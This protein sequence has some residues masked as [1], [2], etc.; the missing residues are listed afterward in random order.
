[1]ATLSPDKKLAW[2]CGTGN[3][4]VARGLVRHFDHIIASDSNVEQLTL[5]CKRTNIHYVLA[6]A[7]HCPVSGRSVDAITVAQALHWFDL[8]GFY[9]EVRRVLKPGG[10]IAVWAYH[11]FQT[12]PE[13]DRILASFYHDILGPYWSPRIRLL[14]ER[15]STL[16]FPFDE[17]LPPPFEMAM[18]WG[19]HDFLGF[20]ASWSP[21][22]AF[23][24]ANGYHPLELI[25]GE[26]HAAWGPADQE[27][28][29]RVPIWL[30]VGRNH[31]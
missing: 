2:D 15:Y 13:I 28:V 31:E 9:S 4:Q 18:S 5:G 27:R 29:S 12:N 25:Q 3:G 10:M 7:E 6:T 16:P 22:P 19:L 8:E 21:V 24:E 1:M 11:L 20:L 30:R 26:L 23:L 14:E 17:I